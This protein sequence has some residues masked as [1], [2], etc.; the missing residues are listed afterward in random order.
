MS[1]L[2]KITNISVIVAAAS[3]TGLALYDRLVPHA[4]RSGPRREAGIEFVQRYSGKRFPLPP[5]LDGSAD[6]TLLLVV[7]RRCHYC[8]ESMPFYKRLASFRSGSGNFRMVAAVPLIETRDED[9]TYFSTHQ[10]V[11][12]ALDP[13]SFTSIGVGSTPTMVL[14]N[15]SK[16][17]KAIWIGKLNPDQERDVLMKLKSLCAQ[18]TIE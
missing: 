16:V 13:V 7:S 2:E 14:L 12:D 15:R 17:V 3:V 18:C 5:S 9:M 1:R 4:E 11:L 8:A 10:I 6:A